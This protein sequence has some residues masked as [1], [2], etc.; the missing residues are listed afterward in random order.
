VTE[1]A[2]T[3][4]GQPTVNDTPGTA[5]GPSAQ[6]SAAAGGASMQERALA[7]ANERPEAA[8]GAAFAGGL[9]LAMI[10]KRLGR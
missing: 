1:D 3:S 2:Q 4:A 10:L 6:P 7:L 8:V 9:L 5:G